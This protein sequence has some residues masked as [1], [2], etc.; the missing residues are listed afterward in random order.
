MES[1]TEFMRRVDEEYRRA[2]GLTE[3]RFYSIFYSQVNPFPILLLGFNPGGDPETWDEA[4]L[5]SQSFYENGEHEYVDCDYEI[6]VAM[7]NFLGEVLPIESSEDIRRI[8]KTNLIFRRSGSMDELKLTNLQ[9][10]LDA[11]PILSQIIRHVAPTTTIC[12]GMT[13]LKAFNQHYCRDVQEEIDGFDIK[14]PNGM[15]NARIYRADQGILLDTDSPV[16]IL[17]IGHPSRYSGRLEWS[18]VM[19]ATKTFLHESLQGEI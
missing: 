7:R 17:G 19:A 5:A 1:S 16:R 14:T 6:A 12:E 8:P 11:K 3:R 4:E 2:S 9:A 15:R 13:T 10:I 18:D